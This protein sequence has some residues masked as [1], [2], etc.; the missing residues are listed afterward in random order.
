[1]EKMGKNLSRIQEQNLDRERFKIGLAKRQ[2]KKP[3]CGSEV[4][5]SLVHELKK[6]FATMQSSFTVE[7]KQSQYI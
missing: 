6:S 5:V 7:A 2:N 1:M 4:N 3:T